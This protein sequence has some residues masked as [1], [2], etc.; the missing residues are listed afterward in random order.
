MLFKTFKIFTTQA[1]S[2]QPATLKKVK[3]T[4][5]PL[6]ADVHRVCACENY[7]SGDL[8]SHLGEFVLVSDQSILTVTSLPWVVPLTKTHSL[9]PRT[10]PRQRAVWWVRYKPNPPSCYWLNFARRPRLQ[11]KKGIFSLGTRLFSVENCPR[12]QR[13]DTVLTNQ[14]MRCRCPSHS[15]RI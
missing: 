4:R 5:D 9:V 6:A 10:C 11:V 2:P 1:S 7:C 3:I 15:P 8:R 13:R 14:N 12:V